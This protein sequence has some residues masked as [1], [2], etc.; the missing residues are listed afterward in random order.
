VRDFWDDAAGTFLDTSD[1]HD[2][3]VARPRGLI[4][5]ATPSANSTGADALARMALLTG[6]EDLARRARSIV[7]AVA[8]ALDRQPSA[9][10]RMLSAA[11]RLMGE[12]IDVVVAAGD[13]AWEAAVA[14]RRAA[15]GPYAPD[16]VQASVSPDDAHR[17]WPL[18]ESKLP[19]DGMPTAYACRGYVC[20]APTDDP[21][22]L[23]EQVRELAGG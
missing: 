9:F 22:R 6:D 14:L 12:P 20:D 4:D 13:P 15:A 8:G 5:N 1:E 23:T 17:S 18:F 2:R 16:L 7:R 3:T 10:G 11:D 21:A 19:R